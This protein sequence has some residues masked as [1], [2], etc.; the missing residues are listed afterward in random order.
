V[1]SV[2]AIMLMGAAPKPQISTDIVAVNCTSAAVD[3]VTTDTLPANTT[4]LYYCMAYDTKGNRSAPSNTVKVTTPNDGNSH[5]ITLRWNPSSSSAVEDIG[6]RIWRFSAPTNVQVK[7][8][9]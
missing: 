7:P 2:L 9:N 8:S 3:C 5:V 6:Y 1:T 4:K